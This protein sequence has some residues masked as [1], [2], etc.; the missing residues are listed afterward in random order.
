MVLDATGGGQSAMWMSTF[1]EA[2]LNCP[3][4]PKRTAWV[5][6]HK[7][8]QCFVIDTTLSSLNASNVQCGS[9]PGYMTTLPHSYSGWTGDVQSSEGISIL[10]DGMFT[11]GTHIE[12]FFRR[13]DLSGPNVGLS[14]LCPDT[15]VVMP[16]AGESSFDGHRWMEVNVLPDRWKDHSYDSHQQ[17][18]V[19]AVR[20]QQRPSGRRT[21]LDR[22][23]RHDWR[24]QRAGS[25]Q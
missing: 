11:P 9:A 16:Q 23:G 12:Y 25:W 18:G 21:R 17:R 19:H 3:T 4:Q 1:H 24:D 14:F 15:T 10:P 7:R 5:L 13:Q 22:S 8:P 20:G 6:S 2:E